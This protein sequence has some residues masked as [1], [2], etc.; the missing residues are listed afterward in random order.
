[1]PVGESDTIVKEQFKRA[2]ALF[3]GAEY[4][5]AIDIADT[6]LTQFDGAGAQ[7]RVD[8]IF[9]ALRLKADAM[10]C[11]G[12]AQEAVTILRELYRRFGSRETP[13]VRRWVARALNK[14]AEVLGQ[15]GDHEGA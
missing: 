5:E 13:I 3:D 12:R 1:M 10:L 8:I 9:P 7:T 14:A 4:E 15:S 2:Y 11:V 6:L